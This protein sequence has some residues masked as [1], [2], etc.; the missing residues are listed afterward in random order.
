MATDEE[1]RRR[2]NEALIAAKRLA[3]E[4]KAAQE[5]AVRQALQDAQK[6]DRERGEGSK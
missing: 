5:A 4:A 3:E 2:L 1:A 6:E